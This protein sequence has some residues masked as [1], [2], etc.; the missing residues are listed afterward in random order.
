LHEEKRLSHHFQGSLS[1]TW[2]RALDEQSDIGL[3]FTGNNPNHLRD[4]YASSDFDRTHTLTVNF[5]ATLPN[6]AREHSLLA[7][8]TND[9]SLTG[10]GVVQSGE[11]YSLYEFYG[12][13]GSAYFG[14]FPTLLNPVL[15]ISNPKEAK[16]AGLTGNPGDRRG[17]N[18]E[19]VPTVNP[20]DLAINYIAPGSKGVPTAAQGNEGDPLDIYET[21]FAP[22]NQRNIFRQATQKRLDISF[23][24]S[25]HPT[26]RISV[27]YEF[28]IFNVTNTTSL[29]VPQDQTQIRQNDACSNT[30]NNYVPTATSPNQGNNC[31]AGYVNYGQI[32]TG[33]ATA[34]QQSALTNLD[35]KPYYTGLGRTTVIPTNIPVGATNA[36]GTDVCQSYQAIPVKGAEACP[37]NGANFGSVTGTIGGN[38]AITMGLHLV[39]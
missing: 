30:A 6:Y 12:A 7:Y 35:Q 13:V 28:N 25:F 34:D 10:I 38:R 26:S 1:Y 15:P 17:S 8:F 29:D 31:A 36:Q 32:A 16:S 33:P 9:W 4:S 27:L 37:N 22:G 23:H 19:Y 39:F 11:P 14:N 5:Q 24:K 21:D 2:S 18:G 20:D 3:F